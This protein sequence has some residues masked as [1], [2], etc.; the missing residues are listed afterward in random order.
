[1]FHHIRRTK[2]QFC[3]ARP[4]SLARPEG[5]QGRASVL[6]AGRGRALGASGLVLAL[7]LWGCGSGTQPMSTRVAPSTTSPS[8]SNPAASTASGSSTERPYYSN[9]PAPAGR[10]Y[11]QSQLANTPPANSTPGDLCGARDLQWLVGRSRTEIPVPVDVSRRR[12]TCTT[13]AITE[14]HSPYRLNIFYDRPSGRV[15]SVRCG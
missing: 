11:Q 1:M 3:S 15:A 10:P 14:D 6:E 4:Q 13:C 12:V 2:R 7:G 5:R 9:D 8:Y